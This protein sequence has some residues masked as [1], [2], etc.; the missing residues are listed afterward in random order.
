M[1]LFSK[2]R[3]PPLQAGGELTIGYGVSPENSSAIKFILDEGMDSDVGFMK[4]FVTSKEEDLTDII[5]DS[6]WAEK[7]KWKKD[8]A[9]KEI[10][11]PWYTVAVTVKQKR[12]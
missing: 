7:R 1:P 11:D 3:P 8:I 6:M 10:L 9:L 5:Q 12:G 2:T 4:L